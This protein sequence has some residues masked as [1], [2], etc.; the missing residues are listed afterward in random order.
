[1]RI[2]RTRFSRRARR[3]SQ[4]VEALHAGADSL[5]GVAPCGIQTIVSTGDCSATQI[6]AWFDRSARWHH[7]GENALIPPIHST[8]LGSRQA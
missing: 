3:L 8:I 4:Q 6:C 2:Q 1:V 5:M 7:R